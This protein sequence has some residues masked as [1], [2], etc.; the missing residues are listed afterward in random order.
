MA[1]KSER[2]FLERLRKHAAET[3]RY[4][5]SQLKPER[6]RAVCRAFLRCIGISFVE[7]EIVAPSTE[8]ADVSFRE[9]RF[10]VRE[11]MREG[12]RRGDEWKLRQ[13]R[14]NRAKS[15]ADVTEPWVS[16]TPMQ[17]S[18]LIDTVIKSLEQKS[19]KYGQAQ[20][21]DIDALVYVNLTATRFLDLSTTPG[22]LSDLEAQGWRSVSILFPPYGLVVHTR[23]GAPSF[24]W[25]QT[26]KMKNEWSNLDDLF[27]PD[28]V[29]NPARQ[30]TPRGRRG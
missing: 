9:A 29:S 20:C 16:P 22:K 4:L 26:G 7:S 25:L 8:P 10:Q 3:I 11:L 17:F 12:R 13:V 23:D 28:S 24:L 21:L 30:P 5:S 14:W 2:M 15:V 27:D 18:E 19:I 6:E 1:K